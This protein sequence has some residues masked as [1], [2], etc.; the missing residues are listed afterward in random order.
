MK[1][2]NYEEL[3]LLFDNRRK[4]FDQQK[5]EKTMS[6]KL[7]IKP[8]DKFVLFFADSPKSSD[9]APD[10]KGYLNEGNGSKLPIAGWTTEKNGE[11][12]ISG[13]VNEEYKK[14]D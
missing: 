10:F 13:V 12:Y 11:P 14:N 5:G 1:S 8:G 7:T 3:K 6:D 9:N 2:L 4:E